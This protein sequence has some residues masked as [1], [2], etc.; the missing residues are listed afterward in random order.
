[1]YNK[2]MDNTVFKID[3]KYSFLTK[4]LLIK[5]YTKNKLTDRQIA[6]K[7]NV[8]SKTIIWNRRKF[9]NIQNNFP[10]KSNNTTHKNKNFNI[11]KEE[12]LQYLSNGF[13]YLDIASRIGCSRIVAYRR[14]KELGIIKN[15][16]KTINKLRWH[17]PLSDTQ[18]NFLLGCM[19]G[20]GNI[21]SGG[22]FQC[23]HSSKQLEYIKYKKELLSNLIAPKFNLVSHAVK[24]NQ[25]GKTYYAYYLR[26]MNNENI[27]NLYGV[28]YINKT[29][30]FPYDY[31]LNSSFNAY[32]LAIWYMDDGSRNNNSV[33]LHTLGYK[34]DGNLK[35]LDF[36]YEKFDIVGKILEAKRSKSDN[37]WYLMLN[38][39]NSN[40]FYSLI[41][42][43][44]LPCFQYKLP[45]RFRS[46]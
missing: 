15:Q 42:P 37:R 41:S 40:K 27:K 35:I 36:L 45:E 28:F 18:K 3:D 33:M 20:D 39:E 29:K 22:M 44:I 17:E 46:I 9:Y 10:N 21:T 23:N 26:T 25:N 6:K 8:K 38:V 24:N 7:Y 11:A 2:S 14:M 5:E 34:L 19:L 43:Y 31:L 12:V 13:T 4:D 16:Y 32:S 1:M 30:I